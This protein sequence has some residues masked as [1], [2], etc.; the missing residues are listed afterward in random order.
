MWRKFCLLCS[1]SFI[2]N[3]TEVDIYALDVKKEGDF[4][5]ANDDVVI[6]SDFYFITANKAIYNEQTGEIELFGDVNILRG[7]NERAH[8]S[9]AKLKLDG[10]E[11]NFENFF[12]TNNNLE[13][14]FQS[15]LSSFDSLK[16]KS[17][18]SA[19]SSCNIENPDWEIRFSEG[20]LNRQSNFVHLYNAKLYVKNIPVF[21][22][23]YFG[24]SA[25]THRQSGLLIPNLVLKSSEGLYYEQPIYFAPFENLDLELNPQ[26]RAKRGF[27]IYS[28][29][30]F[31]D[32][33]SSSGEVSFGIFRENTNYYKKENL[34]EQIHTG[35][36]IKYARES[37]VK[38]LLG[39]NFQE[40]LWVDAT[41]LNDVDYLNL[42]HRDY[43]DLTS[44]ISSKVNYF[45]ADENNFYGMYAKYY[46]DTSKTNN[47]STLQEYPSF[48]Y[49]HFL[50]ELFNEK[51]RYSFDA[52]F[53]KYYRQIGPYANQLNFNLPLSYHNA[54][55]GDLLHFTFTENA[56]ASLINYTGSTD[57]EHDSY[58]TS[59][60]Q[61]NLYTDLSKAYDSYFHTINF[62]LN[63]L[64]V[65]THSGQISEEYLDIEK[66]EQH[67]SLY[68]VQYFYNKKAQ[69]KLKHRF[70]IDYLDKKGQFD[71]LENL[72]TYYFN[73]NAYLNN[74]LVYS[75]QENRFTNI[76]S[77]L[78]LNIDF[79][80]DL[81]FSHAYQNDKYGKYSFIG[82]RTNYRAS[83]N[84][85]LF[86]GIWLDIQRAHP[87][88][89][90]LG[91]T[92]QRKCWNYSLVYRERVDPKLTSGGISARNQ[93]GVYFVFNFYPLGGVKYDFSLKENENKI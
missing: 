23:P 34:K 42:G 64:L 91:Y 38:S 51:I 9:Y 93:S 18:I 65:G 25:D 54:F 75:Y 68:N 58:F 80:A 76:I 10:N 39:D 13:V 40:G 29:L 36:E 74:E 11:G 71:K 50:N 49:H 59:A 32:S 7:Q 62:G 6:F 56:F 52:S 67:L 81:E 66:E 26:I 55:F 70:N 47:K 86:G 28:T 78:S 61:F 44:L 30:R 87:N 53:H 21:Y 22:L 69:K 57:K 41:Y 85:N 79:K 45:L 84:Y 2:L 77:Q 15:K 35:L 24:F 14:W 37:L 88:M 48:Q 4:V 19:V 31:I 89:W 63:Y 90:E 3:A 73:E 1:L 92:Y 8:S 60:H 5:T 43:R 82:T 33:F 16:F 12:F 83:A 17:T 46:I 27:G 20:W 72:L